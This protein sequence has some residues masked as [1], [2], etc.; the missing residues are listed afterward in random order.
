M[1]FESMTL[2]E[3][4]AYNIELSNEIASIKQTQRQMA[5]FIDA[6]RAER[7]ALALVSSMSDAERAALAQVIGVQPAGVGAKAIK[8]GVN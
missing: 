5:A 3:L 2:E 8:T 6:K 4:E 7:A 1:D